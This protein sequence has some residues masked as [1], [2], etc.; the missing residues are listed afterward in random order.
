MLLFFLLIGENTQ[1][2]ELSHRHTQKHINA[3]Q[4]KNYIFMHLVLLEEGIEGK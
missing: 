1:R 2:L 4:Y 3:T